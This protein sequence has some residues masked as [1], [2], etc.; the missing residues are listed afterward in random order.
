MNADEK[1]CPDCAETIKAAA[2]VCKHCGCRFDV[3]EATFPAGDALVAIKRTNPVLIVGGFVGLIIL[4]CGA[5]VLGMY[6]LRPAGPN[7][8]PDLTQTAKTYITKDFLDPE[9]A[10]FQDLFSNDNCVNGKVNGKNGFGAFTGFKD[11][12]YDAKTKKGAI[13]P[14]LPSL[15]DLSVAD[16][17]AALKAFDAYNTAQARCLNGDD[18]TPAI[19]SGKTAPS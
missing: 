3:I 9:G 15:V 16:A 1:T 4:A 11:F 13:S 7:A 12:Y 5:V 8:N 6:Q 19:A 2:R 10:R 14:G 17:H 18:A